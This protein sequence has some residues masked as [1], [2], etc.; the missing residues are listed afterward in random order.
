MVISQRRLIRPSNL[1]PL[2]KFIRYLQQKQSA[3]LHDY[4]INFI[5]TNE[6]WQRLDSG[7]IAFLVQFKIAMISGPDG[8]LPNES[9][10]INLSKLYG[11]TI[12]PQ[13][14]EPSEW[15]PKVYLD[16]PDFKEALKHYEDLIDYWYDTTTG[17]YRSPF[18]KLGNDQSTSRGSTPT[19]SDNSDN[20]D[21][22]KIEGDDKHETN[23]LFKDINKIIRS[24]QTVEMEVSNF[25]RITKLISMATFKTKFIHN[26]RD[27]IMDQRTL[28]ATRLLHYDT[29]HE[30]GLFYRREISGD[31]LFWR[32]SIFGKNVKYDLKKSVTPL[33][34][35]SAKLIWQV[36]PRE[37][38]VKF[39][40]EHIK[41]LQEMTWDPLSNE[42]F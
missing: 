41:N 33:S 12:K 23:I 29:D 15:H 28:L 26:P 7:F 2:L 34:L 38:V 21:E 37:I 39:G 4:T 30:I 13:I 8:E 24:H 11:P 6:Y 9:N 42:Y 22:D 35:N 14:S 17:L 32:R 25:H 20:D 3:L 5:D 19:V 36:V 40:N 27:E 10:K 18:E 16:Y 31:K 1:K